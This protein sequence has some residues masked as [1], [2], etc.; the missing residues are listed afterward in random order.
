MR[1]EKHETTQVV[2]VPVSQAASPHTTLRTWAQQQSAEMIIPA[3]CKPIHRCGWCCQETEVPGQLCER[4]STLECIEC[5][6]TVQRS[7][8]RLGRC[9]SCRQQVASEVS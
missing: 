6:K 1:K 3:N 2:S 7:E 8:S 9:T 5:G 4:C